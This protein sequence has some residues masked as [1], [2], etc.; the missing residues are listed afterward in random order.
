MAEVIAVDDPRA[1]D[2]R[3]VLARHLTFAYDETPAE[4]VHALDIDA[5]VAPDVTFFSCRDEAGRV[6]AV[7]ALKQLDTRHVEIKSMHTIAEARGTG[8]GRRMLQ[9]LLAEARGRGC[10]RVSLETGT[11]PAFAAAHA[12]YASAGF[13]SCPPFGDYRPTPHNT[14][15]TMALTPAPDQR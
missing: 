5:L 12:L 14:F 8:I 2:V 4:A 11:G 9:H 15:M 6:L 10:D 3:A 13:E 7:G 1:D